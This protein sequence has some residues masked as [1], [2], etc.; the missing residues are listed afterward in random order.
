MTDDFDSANASLLERLARP[1]AE[2]LTDRGYQPIDEVNGITVGARVHNSGEQFW[3]AH[4]EGTA[5]V[6]GI[7]EKVGSSWSQTYRARDIEVVV[8]HD[9]G[10]E[11]QWANYRTL[12]IPGTD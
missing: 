11:R 2:Q 7:F 5:T 12:L 10:G 4:A 6:T 8:Q 9:E 3:S 1:A